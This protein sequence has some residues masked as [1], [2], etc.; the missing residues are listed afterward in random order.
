MATDIITVR[1]PEGH[2]VEVV[3]VDRLVDGGLTARWPDGRRLLIPPDAVDQRDGS[4]LHIRMRLSDLERAPSDPAPSSHHE[5]RRIPIV[6]EEAVLETRQRP[7]A[8][9]HVH[10]HTDEREEEV[11]EVLTR[12][13][14]DVKRVK[15]GRFVDAPSPVREEGGTTIV[16]LHEEVLVVEK[17]LVLKEELHL[18]K[19]GEE[20]RETRRVGLRSQRAEIERTPTDEA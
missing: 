19:I 17:R 18:T 5:E 2:D 10:T 3:V 20:R 12:E 14:V 16:P 8:T 7:T 13:S 15:V 1:D 9:V 4:V 6:A 11:D